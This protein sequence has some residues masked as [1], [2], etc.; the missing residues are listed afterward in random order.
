MNEGITRVLAGLGTTVPA[1][2]EPVDDVT[3]RL[4]EAAFSPLGMLVAAIIGGLITLVSVRMQ[5][6]GSPERAFIDRLQK[7]LGDDFERYEKLAVRA[8]GQD[9]K[10]EEYRAKLD[11]QGDRIDELEDAQ[12]RS[13]RIETLLRTY[14]G[15][16]AAHI[17]AGYPPPPPDP[18]AGLTV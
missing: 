17:A 14:V 16:L 2:A 9:K 12:E 6:R 5:H 8:D 11:A 7:Q 15:T 18:P 10:L 13:A 1:R 3:A 4:L